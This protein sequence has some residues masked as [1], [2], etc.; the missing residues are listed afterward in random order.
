MLLAFYRRAYAAARA[1]GLRAETVAFVV[2][3]NP[4][5]P[6]RLAPGGYVARATRLRGDNLVLDVHAYQGFGG[7]RA[8]ASVAA[9]LRTWEPADGGGGREARE[10]VAQLAAAGRTL[11][12]WVVV[13]EWSLR[14]PWT[15]AAAAAELAAAPA[16]AADTAA[17]AFGRAQ[18]LG[19]AAAGVEGRFFWTWKTTAS[20][21][22]PWWDFRKCP[23]RGWLDPAWWRSDTD[24]S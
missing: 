20:A 14:L 8:A 23:R 7:G 16:T 19:M 12:R 2:D 13:G 18:V 22:E 9:I 1:G 10:R 21:A 24:Q 17:R 5:R 15:W 11:D 4:F 3:G 6:D